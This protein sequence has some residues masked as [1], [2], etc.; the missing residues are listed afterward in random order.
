[1][2]AP[3]LRLFEFFSMRKDVGVLLVCLKMMLR[4]LIPWSVVM[5]ITSLGF[6]VTLSTLAPSHVLRHS[7]H[8]SAPLPYVGS[9]SPSRS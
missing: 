8:A 5:I 2:H 1:M 4:D 6:A 7:V 9:P 3:D